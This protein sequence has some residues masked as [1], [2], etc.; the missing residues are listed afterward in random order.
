MLD[1]YCHGYIDKIDQTTDVTHGK[2]ESQ[3]D[4]YFMIKDGLNPLKKDRTDSLRPGRRIAH[5]IST[6][7]E[8]Q[9]DEVV[10]QCLKDM[11][12]YC[13]LLNDSNSVKRYLLMKT[14]DY[15]KVPKFK[16]LLLTGSNDP[17]V[18]P[19]NLRIDKYFEKALEHYPTIANSLVKF[20]DRGN[21]LD[22]YFKNHFNPK[23]DYMNIPI[24]DYEHELNY[25]VDFQE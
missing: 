3:L 18:K 13:K 11:V 23:H 4:R 12:K 22:P 15:C 21:E 17:R 10:Y 19:F 20:L 24:L 7:F 14:M 8:E 25:V 5:D 1:S 16:E 6:V 9:S 2:I